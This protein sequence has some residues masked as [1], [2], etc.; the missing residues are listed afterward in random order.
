MSKQALVRSRSGSAAIKKYL[1]ATA[2]LALIGVGSLAKAADLPVGPVRAPAYVPPYGPPPV[3]RWT[4]LYIGGNIGGAWAQRDVNDSL[5]GLNFGNG[6]SRGLFIGGG[7]IGGN[8]QFGYFVLGVEG[9]FDW[10][11]NNDGGNGVFVPQ[12]GGIVQVTSNNR[13][14]STLAARFGVAFDNGT[15]VYG[16]AGGGWVGNDGFT[17]TNVTTGASITGLNSNTASGWL[18]GGGV[19]WAITPI[20]S[21][22][23][24]YDF[25]GLSS[26]TFTIPVTSP[27]LVG[28]TFTAGNLSVHMVKFGIN[29]KLGWGGPY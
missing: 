5:F 17:V 9:D 2:V 16:K 3:F 11:A 7:Q 6:F 26:R 12:A 29:Y 21:A 13:W 28:D 15:L 4:G 14:V 19:E 23:L 10:A 24:E 22:K 25:L 20:W 1:A 8:Y 18:L 27:F